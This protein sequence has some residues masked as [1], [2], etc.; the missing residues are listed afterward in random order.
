MTGTYNPVIGRDPWTSLATF[1]ADTAAAGYPA[2]NLGTTDLNQ[3]WKATATSAVVSF[4]LSRAVPIGLVVILRHN[5]TQGA[6]FR[7]QLYTD[8]AWSTLKYDSNTDSTLVGLQDV[9]PP[10]YTFPELDYEDDNVWT[11]KYRT[12][13]LAGQPWDRPIWL[14]DTRYLIQSGKVTLTDTHNASNVQFGRLEIAR[15]DQIGRGVPWGGASGYAPNSIVTQADGGKEYG[16]LKMKPRVF[17]ATFPALTR[18]DSELLKD[19]K[20]QHDIVPEQG[21]FWHP[22]PTDVTTWLHNSF[23]AR[24]AE[25]GLHQI[26]NAVRDAVPLSLREVM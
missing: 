1:T 26:A 23:Y 4:T 14:N 24:H 9:W 3:V 17:Q 16:Q 20:R 7:L 5:L 13:Q 8:A 15:G 18:S 19:M 10:S 22:F 2:S 6:T 11:W 12:E 21:V 25:L